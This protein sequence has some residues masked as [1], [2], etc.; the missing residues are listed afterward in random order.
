[1]YHMDYEFVP[2]LG[3]M[4]G[5]DALLPLGYKAIPPR[6]FRCAPNQ[7]WCPPASNIVV[8]IAKQSD[9]W[10][11]VLRNRFDMEVI[12]AQNLDLVSAR[13]LTKPRR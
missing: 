4:I 2:V 11:I 9:N 7:A 1:M 13:Q 3:R 6:E 12:V 5:L 8:S 10:R